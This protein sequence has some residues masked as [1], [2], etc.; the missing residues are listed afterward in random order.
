MR[1]LFCVGHESS[2]WL[3]VVLMRERAAHERAIEASL[4]YPSEGLHTPGGSDSSTQTLGLVVS[5]VTA[6]IKI[7]IYIYFFLNALIFFFW[8]WVVNNNLETKVQI[9][10]SSFNILSTLTSSTHSNIVFHNKSPKTYHIC[11]RVFC[12]FTLFIRHAHGV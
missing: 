2:I 11:R 7:K 3:V 1:T 8:I 4:T 10:M 5:P 9:K 12:I 6:K